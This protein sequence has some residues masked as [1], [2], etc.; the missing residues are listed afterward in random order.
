MTTFAVLKARIATELERDDLTDPIANAVLDAVKEYERERFW[1]NES[2]DLTFSTVAGQRAYTTA[3]GAWIPRVITV[4]DLFLTVSTQNRPLRKEDPAALELLNDASSP[5]GEPYAWAWLNDSIILYP[6]PDD[7][8]TVRA[9]A[10]WRL[11]DL[12]ADGDSNAWTTYAEPLIRYRATQ[13]I[14]Q[15]VSRDAEGAALL[16]PLIAKALADLRAETSR[17]KTTGRIRPTSF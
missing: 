12:S 9:V 13:L 5:N 17:R 14:H 6:T 16:E 11:A 8:Y 7:A 2:R 3:A 10:H 15:T 4:D 1:F